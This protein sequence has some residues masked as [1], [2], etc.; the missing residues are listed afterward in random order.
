MSAFGQLMWCDSPAGVVKMQILI[1][2]TGV[3]LEIPSLVSDPPF[4]APQA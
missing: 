4:R 3:G 2:Q 1:Q